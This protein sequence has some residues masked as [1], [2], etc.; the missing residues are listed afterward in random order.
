MFTRLSVFHKVLAVD[1]SKQQ[2]LDANPKAIEQI[3]FTGNLD[4]TEGATMF[5]ITE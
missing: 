1:L 3:D 4:I 5:F 2:K